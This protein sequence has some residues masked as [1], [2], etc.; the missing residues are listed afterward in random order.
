MSPEQVCSSGALLSS[1]EKAS[2]IPFFFIIISYPLLPL[3]HL[4]TDL[5]P[6]RGGERGEVISVQGPG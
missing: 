5:W 2:Y 1:L 6:G 4:R 3:L